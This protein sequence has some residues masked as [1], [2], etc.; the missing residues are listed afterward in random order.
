MII[1]NKH[2][3]QFSEAAQV[4]HLSNFL[5]L[6]L[7]YD[8][9]NKFK[10]DISKAKTYLLFYSNYFLNKFYTKEYNKIIDLKSD[11]FLIQQIET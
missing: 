8:I 10:R 5:L 1:K 7:V 4:K 11:I 9:I 3:E 2:F 6:F